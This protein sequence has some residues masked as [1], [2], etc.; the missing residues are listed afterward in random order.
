[1]IWTD[2]FQAF[3][4]IGGLL[5]VIVIGVN[6]VGSIGGIFEKAKQGE[7]MELLK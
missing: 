2:C 6:D 3:V 5:V 1:M 7:R 4:M